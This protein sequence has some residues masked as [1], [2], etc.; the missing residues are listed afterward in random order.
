MEKSFRGKE[1]TFISPLASWCCPCSLGKQTALFPT[2]A[3]YVGPCC[4]N[5]SKLLMGYFSS[6]AV[7]LLLLLAIWWHLRCAGCSRLLLGNML[8][9][10]RP[11]NSTEKYLIE[12]SCVSLDTQLCVS[13]HLLKGL[14]K[15]LSEPRSTSFQLQSQGSPCP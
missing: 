14:L 1:K 9:G 2:W 13:K 10:W 5:N 7:C 3:V 6:R 4:F 8:T 11:G 15:G 12:I